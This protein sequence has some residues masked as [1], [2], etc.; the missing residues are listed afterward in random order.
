MYYT[1]HTHT[2]THAYMCNDM[3]GTRK[4]FFWFWYSAVYLYICVQCK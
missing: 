1:C 3:E 2:Y 4:K